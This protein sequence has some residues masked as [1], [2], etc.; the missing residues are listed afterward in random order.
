MAK[1]SGKPYSNLMKK[2]AEQSS[3]PPSTTEQKAIAGAA[4][5]VR[6]R[7]ARVAVKIDVGTDGKLVD[8]GA[9]HAD[10]EG[11]FARLQDAFGSRGIAFP[12]A[13]LSQLAEAC[14]A[15]DGKLDPLRVNAMLAVI[16]GVRPQNEVQAMLAA[17]MAVTHVFSMKLLDRANR[18]SQL[19]QFDSAAS[20]AVKLM[21]TFAL[22]SEVLAKLQRG[23]EQVVKVVHVHPGAQA[24]VGNVDARPIAVEGGQGG[25]IEENG[26]QP[27]AKG[28]LPAPDPARAACAM[29][30]VWSADANR[31]A[32]P[33]TGG[34]G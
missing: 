31:I 28:G 6:A 29:P 1:T 5:S 26:N 32:V 24:I 14:R 13:M 2:N 17:Q 19:P 15:G 4:A 16:D 10:R 21:R 33:I 12:S 11:W 7:R 18:A 25:G 20:M 23:G 8:L 34:R 27:H 9:E 30:E 3:S 22:H